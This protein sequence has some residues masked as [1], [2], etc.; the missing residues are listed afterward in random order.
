LQRLG[1]TTVQ[2]LLLHLPFRYEDR[3]RLTALA[4]LRPGM[5]AMVEGTLVDAEVR[6]GRRSTLVC[7][8][9]DETAALSLRFFHF[10]PAYER[11]LTAGAR[12]RCFGEVRWGVHGLEMAH[13]EIQRLPDTDSPPLPQHLTPVYPA[14]EGLNQRSLRKLVDQAVA[15]IRESPSPAVKPDLAT[16]K[17]DR[18]GE[19]ADLAAAQRFLHNPPAN[20]P[21][22]DLE[23]GLHPARQRLAFDELLAHQLSRQRYR[24]ELR[25]L[26]APPLAGSRKLRIDLQQHLPFKLTHAQTRVVTEISADLAAKIPM[27]RLVQGDVGSGKTVVAALAALQAI[28]CE[29]QVAIMAPTELLTEQH[30]RSFSSWLKP[31]GVTVTE[32]TGRLKSA[33]REDKLA[34]IKSGHSALI[35]GTH[36]LFQAGVEFRRLGL[37]I[38]DEQ[39]RFGVRQRLMLRDKGLAEG[40]TPHQL[41]LTATPI[42]RTLAMAAYAD[43]DTS[44]ID[45]LPPHR[46]PVQTVVVAHHRRQQVIKRVATACR[47]GQQAY[48][49]CCLIEESDAL[50]CQAAVQTAQELTDVLPGVRVA[51][52]HGR[53]RA[54][55]RNETMSAFARGEVDLLV[56]TTVIE[57]G[58]DVP[59]ASLMIIENPERLG[60]AQLHQL[61]G[62]VGRGAAQSHCVLLYKPPLSEQARERLAT[63]RATNDGFQIAQKDMELRGPGEIL[64]TR[65]AGDLQFK[66]AD[67]C[68]DVH[69]LNAVVDAAKNLIA[70]HPEQ[71]ETIV[72]RWL[73]QVENLAGA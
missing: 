29:Y 71:T 21:L 30:L 55:Q 28:E 67:L 65:Q 16:A 15:L 17:M 40:M 48:W 35:I 43:L 69:L 61:R 56:A 6:Q 41:I 5:L 68:R 46:K 37:V 22:A 54:E 19:F 11:W 20:A 58:V 57:V 44:T 25:Q 8:L 4:Q 7:V 64:G 50:Q 38:V 24:A 45:E 36:A 34:R 12:L 73:G 33:E 18:F 3:T 53:M 2:D 10:S 62:R 13:P 52:V 1:I 70:Q 42:P 72:K 49:V 14:T 39:H 51:L 31:L 32:L 60:L 27:L 9:H 66:V 59:R 26:Q 47:S 23:A 63:L